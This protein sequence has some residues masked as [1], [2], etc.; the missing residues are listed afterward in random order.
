MFLPSSIRAKN[1]KR[2]RCEKEQNWSR[3]VI[4]F[5]TISIFRRIFQEKSC[6]YYSKID[7]AHRNL[8]SNS[9]CD[10]SAFACLRSIDKN[11]KKILLWSQHNP[12]WVVVVVVVVKVCTKYMLYAAQRQLTMLCKKIIIF[13]R[14]NRHRDISFRLLIS[15]CSFNALLFY[16]MLYGYRKRLPEKQNLIIQIKEK[17]KNQ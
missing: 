15:V 13:Y 14:A 8:I 5:C 12:M 1:I 11:N 6:S 17:C 16:Y 10:A 9:R 4:D 2:R 3:L 7:Q